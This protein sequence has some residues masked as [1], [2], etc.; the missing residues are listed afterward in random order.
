MPDLLLLRHAKSDW[1]S[2]AR[3][4]LDRPLNPRG[5]AAARA[6]GAHLATLAPIDEVWAS[7]ATRV[8][9]TLEEVRASCPALPRPEV[10]P[11]LYGADPATLL[12]LAAHARAP[13]LL[14]VGHNP[15]MQALAA[16]LTRGDEGP[17]R[18]R[19]ADKYPT[20]ALAE[21]RLEAD[22]SALGPRAAGRLVRFVRPRDL[23]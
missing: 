8:A 19:L 15:S 16:L 14:L 12:E 21:I 7:P 11:A 5:R 9:E 23:G 2:A 3:R 17:L 6:I 22:W 20:A 1:H 10:V 4:D 18:D 13:R